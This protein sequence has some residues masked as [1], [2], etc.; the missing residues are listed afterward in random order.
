MVISEHNKSHEQIHLINGE[1]CVEK[2]L[3]DSSELVLCD[4]AFISHVINFKAGLCTNAMHVFKT[5]KH[6]SEQILNQ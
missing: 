2:D 1:N 4:C 5:V 3:H 6:I